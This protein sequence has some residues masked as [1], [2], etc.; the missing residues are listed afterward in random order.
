MMS[1]VLHVPANHYVSKEYLPRWG[2]YGLGGEQV[3]LRCAGEG[4]SA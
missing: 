4:D 3:A 2:I 1:E